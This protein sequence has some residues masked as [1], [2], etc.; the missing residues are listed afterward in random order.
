[1]QNFDPEKSDMMLFPTLFQRQASE[2]NLD[3]V[4]LLLFDIAELILREPIEL[5]DDFECVKSKMLK[6]SNYARMSS[7]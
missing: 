5:K 3:L 6:D 2:A 1:M 7:V 4:G